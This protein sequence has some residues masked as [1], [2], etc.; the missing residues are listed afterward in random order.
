[1]SDR[2]KNKYRIESA[3]LKSWDYGWNASYFIAICTANREHLFGEI[4]H[5]EMILS[6]IGQIVL[7]EWEKS[8]EIHRELFCDA[9]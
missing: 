1:M 2:F 8:F 6:E 4:I 9:L 3:R 5:H 7:Q